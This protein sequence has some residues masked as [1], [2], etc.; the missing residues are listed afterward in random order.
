[1]QPIIIYE[2]GTRL[3]ASRFLACGLHWKSNLILATSSTGQNEKHNTSQYVK[4]A[5]PLEDWA[6]KALSSL[7]EWIYSLRYVISTSRPENVSR[8]LLSTWKHISNVS[9][10]IYYPTLCP[11]YRP[12]CPRCPSVISYVSEISPWVMI[13]AT[14]GE[15]R[16]LDLGC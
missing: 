14:T 7:W 10:W 15:Y 16:V 6:R 8:W 12:T 4:Q 1:M 9:C 11:L 5:Y 13:I 2:S 3:H